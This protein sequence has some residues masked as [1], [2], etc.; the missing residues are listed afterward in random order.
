MSQ[1]TPYCIYGPDIKF[2][3]VLY[4]LEIIVS[5]IYIYIVFIWS[6]NSQIIQNSKKSLLFTNHGEPYSTMLYLHNATRSR[7]DT[8]QQILA[9]TRWVHVPIDGCDPKVKNAFTASA[10]GVLLLKPT[11]T[12]RHVK[13]SSSRMISLPKN[14]SLPEEFGGI[15]YVQWFLLWL[16][17]SSRYVELRRELWGPV[18]PQANRQHSTK[19]PSTLKSRLNLGSFN[20][21]I[22]H[23]FY[24]K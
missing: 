15:W 2:Y 4:G 6:W 9:G 23:E 17:W 20:Q 5:M 1:D 12:R 19:W 18:T 8:N 14:S 13:S 24:A 21:G 22:Y 10:E 7:L 11:R 3:H 16:P